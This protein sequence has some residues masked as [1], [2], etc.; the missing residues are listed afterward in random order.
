MPDDDSF[1]V[2]NDQVDL[3][4]TTQTVVDS[5]QEQE[6]SF[7][8]LDEEKYELE[9]GFI[10]IWTRKIRHIN[11]LNTT[12]NILKHVNPS[13]GSVGWSTFPF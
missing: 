11:I 4:A 9:V 13:A 8:H 10:Q 12:I 2:V 1:V 6:T 7:E 3:T 5:R